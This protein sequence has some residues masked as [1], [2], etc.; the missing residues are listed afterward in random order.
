MTLGMTK[1]LRS[2]KTQYWVTTQRSK[3]PTSLNWIAMFAGMEIGRSVTLADTMHIVKRVSARVP[4]MLSRAPDAMRQIILEQGIHAALV[5]TW[6]SV[7][8]QTASSPP[9]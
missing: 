6:N 2:F 5:A 8:S 9:T 7:M 1:T 4:F 3:T